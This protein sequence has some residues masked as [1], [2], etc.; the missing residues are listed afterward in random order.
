[1]YSSI[2]R[3]MGT[4]LLTVPAN[5]HMSFGFSPLAKNCDV[6]IYS[7]TVSTY[8]IYILSYQVD[9]EGQSMCYGD[10][11]LEVL[12]VLQTTVGPSNN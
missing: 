10:S 11:V 2:Y 1:M 3:S 4:T 6:K 5:C 12:Q 8:S 7:Y 9:I